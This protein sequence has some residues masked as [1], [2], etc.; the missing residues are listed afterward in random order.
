MN[1]RIMVNILTC[2]RALYG[3]LDFSKIEVRLKEILRKL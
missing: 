2:L 3:R 1:F